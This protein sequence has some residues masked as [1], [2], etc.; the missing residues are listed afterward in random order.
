V[1]P[2]FLDKFLLQGNQACVK[3]YNIDHD[4]ID[5]I[6]SILQGQD[7]RWVRHTLSICRGRQR[8]IIDVFMRE[9]NSNESVRIAVP[10][11]QVHDVIITLLDTPEVPS[12][13]TVQDMSHFR[14]M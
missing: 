8:I 11:N 14:D 2:F 13:I 3:I 9:V 4:I 12:V 7:K 1:V 5:E 6:S 10:I